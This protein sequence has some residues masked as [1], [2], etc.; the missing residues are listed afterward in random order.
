MKALPVWWPRVFARLHVDQV[1]THPRFKFFGEAGEESYQSFLGVPVIDRG[2]LQGVLVVQTVEA[3]VFLADEIR[4]LTEAATEV[5]PVISQARTLGRFIAPTQERLWAM[6]RN[7]GWSWDH[8]ITSIFRELDPVRFRALNHNP[9]SLLLEMPLATIE[10]RA[11][12]LMLHSRI[13]DAY[14]AASRNI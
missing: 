7:L 9:I 6:A 12:E 14:R 1:A 10:R 4:I 13:N 3:R 2:E 11:G 8:E 5:A